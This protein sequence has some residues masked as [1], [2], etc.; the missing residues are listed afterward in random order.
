MHLIFFFHIQ[1][2]PLLIPL[3]LSFSFTLK[4]KYFGI[5]IRTTITI[6]LNCGNEKEEKNYNILSNQFIEK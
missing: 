4:Q 6:S 2:R 3:I 5:W 1:T